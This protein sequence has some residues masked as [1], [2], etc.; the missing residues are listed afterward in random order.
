MRDSGTLKILL[1]IH[2]APDH[3]KGKLEEILC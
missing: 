2:L 3:L 1:D